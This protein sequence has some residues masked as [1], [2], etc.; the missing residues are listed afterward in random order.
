MV[1]AEGHG[2]L[3][4]VSVVIMTRDEAHNIEACLKSLSEFSEIIV[5]DNGSQD[6]TCEIIKRFSNT[7]LILSEWK[8]YGGTRQV[9]VDAASNDWILWFDADERMTPEL[10][11]EIRD[12]LKDASEAC[13][14]SFPRRN[15]FLGRAIRGCGWSPDHVRRIFNRKYSRF[16]NK[17]VHE[18]IAS[19][20]PVVTRVL[21]Q[22]IIHYSYTSLKQFFEKNS[23]YALLA[24]AERRRIGR[25]VRPVELF[26]RPIWEFFRCYV[27]KRGFMD[28]L[29]GLVIC[30]GSAIYVFS[31]DAHCLLEDDQR[32][33]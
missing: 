28:G 9:G 30:F 12:G 10:A 4:R 18:G 20:G 22:P 23:R 16:D 17:T 29:R 13:I 7:K 27:L 8:G 3:K 25:R 2:D 26:L 15:F 31:R 11:L 6:K 24:G 5:V 19:N 1:I 32:L 14:F 33:N 21:K